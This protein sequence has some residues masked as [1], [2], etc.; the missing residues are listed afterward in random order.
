M[1][2][3]TTVLSDGDRVIVTIKNHTALVTGNISSP[4][5]SDKDVKEMGSKISEFEIVIADKVNTKELEAEIAR[6]NDLTADNVTIKEKLTASAAEID[7]L[8][9]KNIEVDGKLT[10]NSA[11]IENVKAK[12]LTAEAADIS[13]TSGKLQSSSFTPHLVL[14]ETLLSETRQLQENWSVSRLKAI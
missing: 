3:S 10:A 1:I 14:S 4:S 12:M 11:E 2:L 8:K 5:A 6:I 13:R 7:D 9:A